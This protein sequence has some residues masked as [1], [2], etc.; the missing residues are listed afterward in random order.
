MATYISS[1]NN[2]FY[3]A[4]ESAYAQVPAIT[5]ANRLPTVELAAHQQLQQSQRR[6]K[7]GTRTFLGNSPLARRATA[8]SLSTYLTSWDP[9]VT[10]GYG[11]L[12]QSATGG[13]PSLSSQLTVSSMLDSLHLVTS[14]PHGLLAGNGVSQGS[15][16]RFVASVVDQTTILLN[17]PFSSPPA[18][19]ALL[20]QTLSYPL[21][22]LL[23]SVSL[24]DY[25]DPS[26]AIDRIVTG[27]T[28]DTMTISLNGAYHEMTFAGL[29][30][31]LLDSQSLQDFPAEPTLS[32][33]DYSIVSGN[34]GEAWLGFTA[35]Q[36]FT[37]TA[38][39][40]QIKNNLVP[41]NMEFGTIYPQSIAAGPR[42]VSLNF[43]LYADDSSMVKDLY[44][45]AKQRTPISIMFQLGQQQGQMLGIYLPSIVPELPLY[46]DQEPRLV[47]DFKANIAQGTNNDEIYL[48]LA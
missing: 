15:E 40:I 6:D 18:A 17:A 48:A 9:A 47:W 21:G 27:A 31:D 12:L 38:A 24:F 35:Q 16:V 3:S 41:R 7:T 33:F 28:V 25:W 30:S 23:P 26:T 29:A 37:L 36:L 42:D 43:S 20:S 11:P 39:T 5:A 8:F 19:G 34:L 32:A 22:N 2:R 1:N 46:D 10:P 14:L 4:L 45:A 13:V 44:L